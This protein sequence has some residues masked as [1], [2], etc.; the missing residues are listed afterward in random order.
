LAADAKG[1]VIGGDYVLA[2]N[3]IWTNFYSE[4]TINLSGPTWNQAQNSKRKLF[5]TQFDFHF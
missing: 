4:Q 1:W 2:K 3:I 5:R